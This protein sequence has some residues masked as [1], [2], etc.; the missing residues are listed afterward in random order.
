MAA[1]PAQYAPADSPIVAHELRSGRTLN[2]RSA[3]SGTSCVTHVSTCG[4]V[5]A[6][7]TH[8]VSTPAGNSISG[9][10]MTAGDTACL[11]T[12]LSTVLPKPIESIHCDGPPGS[13]LNVSNTGYRRSALL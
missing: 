13:P 7:L 9:E 11:A 1:M 10:I 12:A 8:S 3:Q 2:A 6:P 5:P 4:F